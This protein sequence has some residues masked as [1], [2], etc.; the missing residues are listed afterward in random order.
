LEA[1]APAAIINN[2][3]TNTTTGSFTSAQT[4]HGGRMHA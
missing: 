2:T 3:T 1:Q 4:V